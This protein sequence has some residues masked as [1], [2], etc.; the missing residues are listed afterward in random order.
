LEHCQEADCD[1][2]IC[3]P[4]EYEQYLAEEDLE[5]NPRRRA[6]PALMVN[7]ARLAVA[8]GTVSLYE[9]PL[10]KMKR[11]L[12]AI[13]VTYNGRLSRSVGRCIFERNDAETGKP[14]TSRI[15]A[16]YGTSELVPI[17][18]EITSRYQLTQGT[19]NNTLVHEFCHAAH[20]IVDPTAGDDASHGQAWRELME[21]SGGIPSST[22]MA[23]EVT[24]QR[25]AA[26]QRRRGAAQ[27]R[28]EQRSA[29]TEGIDKEDLA[30]G[31]TVYF[32]N[33]R[34]AAVKGDVAKL[35]PTRARVEVAPTRERPRGT[36]WD[37]R[38][39]SLSWTRP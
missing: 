29:R 5:E 6:P 25:E 11:K 27:K 31:D 12:K 32:V 37:V 18:I 22:C 38:Y 2:L 4:G 17:A 8:E 3:E 23:P 28:Y 15:E 19:L 13:P 14:F 39:E 35:N 1:I 20:M 33:R 7:K 24:K 34:G 26:T 9:Y 21:A 36:F 16:M 10:A 30:L